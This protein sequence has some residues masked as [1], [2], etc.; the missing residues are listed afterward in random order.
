MEASATRVSASI[1]S[2]IVGRSS[3]GPFRTITAPT[4][5]A[6]VAGCIAALSTPEVDTGG[7]ATARASAGDVTKSPALLSG[8]ALCL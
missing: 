2:I 5:T 6:A 7:I 8:G 3:L 4:V 1:I